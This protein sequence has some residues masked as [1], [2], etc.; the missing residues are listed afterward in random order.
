MMGQTLAVTHIAPELIS[1][2]N[3]GHCGLKTPSF[4]S[5]DMSQSKI[6]S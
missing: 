4:W 5:D 1:L 6:A 3:Y 2:G